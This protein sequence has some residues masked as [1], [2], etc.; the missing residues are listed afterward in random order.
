MGGMNLKT[1]KIGKQQI[2]MLRENELIIELIAVDVA[3]VIIRF[4]CIFN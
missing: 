4:R 1:N 2:D 3:Q